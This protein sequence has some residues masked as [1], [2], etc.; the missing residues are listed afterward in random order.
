MAC[1]DWWVQ[2][3]RTIYAVGVDS[4]HY[5][6][7][8][9]GNRQ[10]NQK[11]EAVMHYILFFFAINSPTDSELFPTLAQCMEVRASHRSLGYTTGDCVPQSFGSTE[12]F[13]QGWKEE[14]AKPEVIEED[15]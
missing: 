6:S 8:V 3:A 10:T 12:A 9:S 14:M 7:F 11:G 4:S 2:L 13:K 1:Q 15:I 5:N